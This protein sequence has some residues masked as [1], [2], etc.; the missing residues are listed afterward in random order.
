VPRYSDRDKQV[1]LETKQKQTCPG[2]VETN[3]LRS[4]VTVNIPR[5]Q[6][7][8]QFRTISAAKAAR[9]I[10]RGVSRNKAVI[11]FPFA[12]G[13]VW[14]FYRIFPRVGEIIGVLMMRNLRRLRIAPAANG[15]P[16]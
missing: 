6:A 4:A 1:E 12:I 2:R 5:E 8:A 11:V 3:I 9:I 16:E 7:T 10:L 14:R 13:I 15:T